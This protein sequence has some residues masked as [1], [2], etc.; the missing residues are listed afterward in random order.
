MDGGSYANGRKDI[1][2]AVVI[3]LAGMVALFEKLD[4]RYKKAEKEIKDTLRIK[5]TKEFRCF[6]IGATF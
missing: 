5:P 6:Y 2:M 3:V 4:A 1:D